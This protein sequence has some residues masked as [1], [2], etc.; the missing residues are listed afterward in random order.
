MNMLTA[1]SIEP[2]K[3][4][5]MYS[6]PS[7][8]ISKQFPANTFHSTLPLTFYSS[9]IPPALSGQMTGSEGSLPKYFTSIGWTFEVYPKMNLSLL[10]FTKVGND[11]S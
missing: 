7:Y 11:N 2:L 9:F 1:N 8:G 4:S 5:P 3:D 10:L 6:N